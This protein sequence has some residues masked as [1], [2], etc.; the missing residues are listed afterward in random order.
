MDAGAR[1]SPSACTRLGCRFALDDF[2]AGFSSF[3]YLKHLPLDYLKIDGD[4]V[5]NLAQQPDR[6][7]GR[8]VDGRDRP[9]PRA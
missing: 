2:G 5:R 6:P 7:A 3:Y 4:F 8:E 9:R 1:R